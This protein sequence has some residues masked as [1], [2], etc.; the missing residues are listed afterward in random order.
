MQGKPQISGQA[1]PVFGLFSTGERI[2]RLCTNQII[3]APV[4]WQGGR[5]FGSRRCS[6]RAG[7]PLLQYY[8]RVR[9]KNS[10]L[11]AKSSKHRETLPFRWPEM[12]AQTFAEIMCT[13][14]RTEFSFRSDD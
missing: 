10:M 12:I 5:L 11:F 13:K 9:G 8:G 2:Q 6:T 1:I 3:C 7:S 4:L 14:L